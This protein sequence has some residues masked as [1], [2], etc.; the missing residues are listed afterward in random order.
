MHELLLDS[1]CELDG[2]EG[3]PESCQKKVVPG[4]GVNQGTG[5]ATLVHDVT[6]D[7]ALPRRSWEQLAAVKRSAERARRRASCG[8]PGLAEVYRGVGGVMLGSVLCAVLG[9]AKKALSQGHFREGSKGIFAEAPL[10][11]GQ[12]HF[13]RGTFGGLEQGEAGA[14]ILTRL[15]AGAVVLLLG[16]W[17]YC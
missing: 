1:T 11:R 12:R 3:V 7:V 16:L 15:T 6:A 13:R 4:A 14:W 10:R 5:A 9:F 2:V 17:C 8:R